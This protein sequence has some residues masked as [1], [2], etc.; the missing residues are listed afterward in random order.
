MDPGE[1]LPLNGHRLVTIEYGVEKEQDEEHPGFFVHRENQRRTDPHGNCELLFKLTLEGR[2]RGF[3][4]F[5]LA[6][7]EFPQATHMPPFRPTGEQD[8]PRIIAN[9]GGDD[10]HGR[11]T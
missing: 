10:D 4:A 11:L 6:P 7:G 2:R 5:D 8:L 3:S 1:F 9:D